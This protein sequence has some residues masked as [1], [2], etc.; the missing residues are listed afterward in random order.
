MKR[1]PKPPPKKVEEIPEPDEPRIVPEP[2]PTEIVDVPVSKVG[3]ITISADQ[4]SKIFIDGKEIKE[5]PLYKYEISTGE[6]RIHIARP[7]GQIKK[8]T[9]NI[10]PND[11]LIYQWSFA[12]GR[13]LINGN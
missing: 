5:A 7:N 6:H 9:V 1:K 11:T 4:S 12:E 2:E 10:K 13:W 3:R 8:F